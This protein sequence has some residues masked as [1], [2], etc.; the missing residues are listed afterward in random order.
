MTV[1][2][3]ALLRS[4]PHSLALAAMLTPEAAS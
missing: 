2:P 1:P 3:G 4:A